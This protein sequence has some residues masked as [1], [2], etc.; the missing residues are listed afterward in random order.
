MQVCAYLRNSVI[1]CI[2]AVIAVQNYRNIVYVFYYLPLTVNAFCQE[3][4]LILSLFAAVGTKKTI[5][6]HPLK[7]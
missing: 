5:K 4:I 6:K 7:V 2:L 1:Y 3:R